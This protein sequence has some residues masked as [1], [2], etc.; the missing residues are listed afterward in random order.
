MA[1]GIGAVENFFR[2]V[3]RIDNLQTGCHIQAARAADDQQIR[4]LCCFCRFDDAVC[5]VCEIRADVGIG[6]ARVECA[7][8]GIKTGQFVGKICCVDICGDCGNILCL[9]HFVCVAGESSHFMTAAC[10]FLNDCV[11]DITSCTDNCDF[12][13]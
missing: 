3:G 5:A 11:A 4:H 2:E 8:H 12:H 13:V 7:D 9:E 10:Q 6:P 1:C